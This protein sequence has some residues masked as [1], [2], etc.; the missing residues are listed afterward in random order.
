VLQRGVDQRRRQPAAGAL[1]GHALLQQQQAEL[2]HALVGIGRV[3]G[4]QVGRHV[5]RGHHLRQLVGSLADAGHLL[6]VQVRGHAR[7]VSRVGQVQ[8]RAGG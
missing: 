7:S 5:V 3:L 4:H 8:G 6:L 2:V 1:A